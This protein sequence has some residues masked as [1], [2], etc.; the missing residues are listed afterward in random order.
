M[1]I[2]IDGYVATGKGTTAKL[3]A[4]ALGYVYMDT[5]SMYRATALHLMRNQ[6]DRL[7]QEAMTQLALE[8]NMSYVYNETNDNYDI[9][10]NGENVEG[11]IRSTDVSN[12]IPYFTFIARVRQHLVKQQQRIGHAAQPW[13]V[14]DWRDQWTVVFPDAPLKVF[15]TCD[16]ETRVTRRYEQLISKWLPA[17]RNTIRADI[18][19]R[20]DA[21]YLGPRAACRQASDAYVLDT[22]HRTIDEQVSIVLDWFNNLTH[23]SS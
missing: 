10:M 14:A 9:V 4:K 22:S 7:D 11:L 23:T 6:V 13:L 19:A 3:V 21:D 15:M 8:T 20:D 1:I 2:T 12:K 5:G 18:I 17:D 16:V